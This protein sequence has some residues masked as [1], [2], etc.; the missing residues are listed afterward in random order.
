MGPHVLLMLQPVTARPVTVLPVLVLL[1][2]PGTRDLRRHDVKKME[3]C[4]GQGIGGKGRAQRGG[5]S[6]LGFEGSVGIRR[7][8][9]ASTAESDGVRLA[10]HPHEAQVGEH[11]Q[12]QM[13]GYDDSPRHVRCFNSEEAGQVENHSFVQ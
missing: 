2:P 9:D 7:W 12:A 5:T 6:S 4:A 11:C 1:P 10:L 8:E 3:S 13:V